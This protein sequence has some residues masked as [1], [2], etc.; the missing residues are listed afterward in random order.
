MFIKKLV[1]ILN[2]LEVSLCLSFLHKILKVYFQNCFSYKDPIPDYL[3]SSLVY[4]YTCA[5]SSSIYIGKTCR[6]FKTTIEDHINKDKKL[7]SFKH[8]HY[9]TAWFDSRNSVFLLK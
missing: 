3:K 8:L 1:L 7:H 2:G 5:S 6:Y 4:K 9:T